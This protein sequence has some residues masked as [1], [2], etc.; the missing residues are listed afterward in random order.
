MTD[1]MRASD[2]AEMIERCASILSDLED[3]GQDG[4][5]LDIAC[6]WDHV[7][8]ATEQVEWLRDEI[9]NARTSLLAEAAV[10]PSSAS[11]APRTEETE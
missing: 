4:T 1:D 5:A 2:L 9:R 8:N 3:L 10:P 7:E 6:A 11:V